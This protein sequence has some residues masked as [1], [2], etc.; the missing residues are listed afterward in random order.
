MTS[1][2]LKAFIITI[3]V[4]ATA[5]STIPVQAAE[6][7]NVSPIPEFSEFVLSVTDGEAGVVRGVYVPNSFAY[8][9]VQQPVED[10]G[11]VSTDAEMV[12]Q[13]S[14][15]NQYGVTG[16]LAH[17]YL[18]G[19]AFSELAVGQEI[20][21]VY[22]DGDIEYYQVSIIS[23]FR[24]IDP[25]SATSNFIDLSTNVEYTVQDIFYQFYTGKEHVTF[26][27]CIAKGSDASWGRLFV[28]AYPIPTML[29]VSAMRQKS[30]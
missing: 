22:G 6:Q 24:A 28:V 30:N 26:Q 14:S 17:N 27:T 12:T 8:Q 7:D 29:K 1:R 4:A 10:Y 19:S 13:F 3:I 23:S 16:L 2:S 15:A 25:L 9:V 11:Y 21:V 20:R 18:A 5:F